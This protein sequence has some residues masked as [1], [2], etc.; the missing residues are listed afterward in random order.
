[1]ARS[2]NVGFWVFTKIQRPSRE[3]VAGLGELETTWISDAMNR[4]GGMEGNILPADPG[5]HCAGPAVTVRVAP[6]DN[7][8]MS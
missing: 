1:M 4:F 3:V 8:V 7:S 2:Q 6:G 5:M